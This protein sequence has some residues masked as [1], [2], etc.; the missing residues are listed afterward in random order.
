VAPQLAED[1]RNGERAER[2][3]APRIE[4]VDRVHEPNAGHLLQVLERLAGSRVAAREHVGETHV[5]LDQQAACDR[6]RRFGR[7]ARARPRRRAGG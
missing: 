6:V 1:R 3:S 4:A 7:A 5:P 2:R